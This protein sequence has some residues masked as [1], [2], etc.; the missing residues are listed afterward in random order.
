M[1]QIGMLIYQIKE[2]Y[3]YDANLIKGSDDELKSFS[4]FW[5]IILF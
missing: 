4:L 1:I 3:I 2:L 5:Y